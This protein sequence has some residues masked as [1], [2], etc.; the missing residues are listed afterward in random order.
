[1][2]NRFSPARQLVKA[3]ISSACH[4]VQPG[5]QPRRCGV[6]NGVQNT[7]GSANG[8]VQTR[9]PRVDAPA[10]GVGLLLG[11]WAWGWISKN[12]MQGSGIAT[13]GVYGLVRGR[14][15]HGRGCLTYCAF[16]GSWAGGLGRGALYGGGGSA[17]L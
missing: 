10:D 17:G 15:F 9:C 11:G 8:F 1:M 13:I 6:S 16:Y 7:S 12:R 5:I 14:C 4:T 3:F 2:L